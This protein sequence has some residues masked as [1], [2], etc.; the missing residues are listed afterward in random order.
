MSARDRFSKLGGIALETVGS[1]LLVLALYWLFMV[2]LYALFPSGT[3]LKEMLANRA[4]ELPVKDGAGRRPEA[5]LKSLV[6][7]VRFRRGNSVAWEGAREGMLLYNNDAVQTFDRSGATLSF[8]PSDRLTVGSNSLVLVT[9]L[10]EKVEGEPRAYRVQVEGELR[11]SLS[12]E[13]RLRLE[14][15]T[16]GHLARVASGA[17]RFR[18]TPNGNASSLAV[19]AG[20]VRVQGR[21]GMVRVPAYHGITLR[22][23]VAAGPAVPLPEAPSLESDKLLYRF[24]LLPPKVRFSW[25]GKAGEYHFQL[26]RDPRFKSLVL[27]KK[28]AAPE[29]VTGTLD[30]GSYFW[31]V[32]GVMEAREGFF[33]RTGRCD[34]LQLLKPPELKVDFPPESAA[35]GNF[36]LTGNVE[37]GA[38]V[39]VNGVEVS[40][41]GDRAFA[42]DLKLKSG[43]NLIRV[44]AVDQAGN[45]SYA[46]RVIY[47]TGA[48]QQGR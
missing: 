4:E 7:D 35:A 31:R 41:A 17:A 9:R 30:A 12:N 38:R 13:K 36:T 24:R 48:G 26:A 46:S 27:D 45:A 16:A 1:L 11:G 25:S 47:G 43:V 14:I 8:A 37:P 5:A 22:K 10:N 23:G 28:L 3:P 2:F 44:E 34:L 42:H 15:A 33:S 40:G 29:L 18:V 20:E 39:F 6:R 19:Y 21:D 32:S